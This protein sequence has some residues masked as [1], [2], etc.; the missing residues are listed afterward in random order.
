MTPEERTLI[1]GLFDRLKTAEGTPKD[2]EADELIR[3]RLAAQ[4]GAPYFMTQTI[5]VQEEGLKLAQQRITELEKEL[6]QAKAATPAPTTSFLG[7]MTGGVGPWGRRAPAAAAPSPWSNSAAAAAPAY[8]QQPAYQQQPYAQPGFGSG[9]GAGG[10]PSFLRSA[11][12]TAAGVAGGAL[13]FGGIQSLF[14]HGGSP[15]GS[16][17]AAQPGTTEIIENTTVNNYGSAA[18]QQDDPY[19]SDQVADSGSYDDSALD[20]GSDFG[21]DD[22]V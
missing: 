1:A 12:T 16:A 11:M 5:L 19:R 18:P 10:Q 8:G 21:G 9:F 20:D 3:Q 22:G 2:P 15:F 14:N 17:L 6:E 7:G 13:L 4:P